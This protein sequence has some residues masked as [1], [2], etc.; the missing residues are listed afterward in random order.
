MQVR[1]QFC[2]LVE[3]QDQ[4]N[5][6]FIKMEDLWKFLLQ[7]KTVSGTPMEG[8]KNNQQYLSFQN[9][10]VW[11]STRNGFWD[12]SLNYLIKSATV[13]SEIRLIKPHGPI[14]LTWLWYYS[15]C[16]PS[17]FKL[18]SMNKLTLYV[19]TF[20]KLQLQWF[21]WY[22]LLQIHSVQEDSDPHISEAC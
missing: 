19:K 18:T 13:K 9:W 17:H 2:Y 11:F 12:T 22:H 20:L 7:K 15:I 14:E 21:M 5:C 1:D 10:T 6:T 3:L 8:K 16:Q 4:R